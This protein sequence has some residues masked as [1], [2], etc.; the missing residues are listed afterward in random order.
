MIHSAGQGD[1]KP[2]IGDTIEGSL[3]PAARLPAC[4]GLPEVAS[5]QH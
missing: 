1:R 4:L 2:E 5:A 3:Q